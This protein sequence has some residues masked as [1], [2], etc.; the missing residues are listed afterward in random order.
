[1]SALNCVALARYR[2]L[3]L[4]PGIAAI[5]GASSARAYD[6]GNRWSA[7]QIDG[8]GLQRGDPVTLRWSIVPDGV[9][10][11]RS[12]AGK[13]S[14]LIQF[15]DDGWNVPAAQRTPDFTNRPWWDVIHNA[16]AQY[17]RV[18]AVTLTYVAERTATGGNTG[19]VGDI[20]LGGEM[21][22]DGPGGALADNVYPDGGDM[23]IDTTKESNGTVGFYFSSEPGLRNLV[24]H[25]TGHGVGLGH[26]SPQNNSAK[27]VMEGGLRTDIWGLQF[28]DIYGLNRLYGDP[29]ESN[30]GNDTYAT[31]IDLGSFT[32]TGRAAMGLDAT[33]TAVEQM[34]GDWLGIDGRN[35]PDWFKFSVSGETFAKLQV[36][37]IGPTYE[38]EELGVFNASAQGDLVLQVYKVEPSS[39]QIA[40][41]DDGVVGDAETINSLYV[42]P[43]DYYLRVRNKLDTNQFYR[44]DLLLNDSLPNAGT[45]ADI[46]LDGD[47]NIDDWTQ[48]LA[49]SSTSFSGL[50]DFGAFRLGDLDLDGDND[51]LDFKYFKEAF[52][53]T[54][55]SGSFAALTSVP[56]PQAALLGAMVLLGVMATRRRQ[57]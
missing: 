17:A 56:E 55:G 14:D 44:V 42:A 28:D 32:T 52:D 8:G 27:A 53:L 13:T 12:S 35:D 36:K 30:G 19:M 23:R 10:Y 37:P 47:T 26:T 29:Y 5:A 3:C 45:S 24:I 33:D 16:Y 18:S 6:L 20:R 31:A 57:H 40:A 9:S 7:T 4:I 22:G 49:N 51:Y 34:D 41:V 38:T 2:F 50:S 39:Q 21:F 54:N 43:G 46:N 11:E 15:L 25:E 1:M 48:F